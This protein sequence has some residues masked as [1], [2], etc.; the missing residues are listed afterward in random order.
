MDVLGEMGLEE[1]SADSIKEEEMEVMP[2]YFSAVRPVLLRDDGTFRTIVRACRWML[3]WG[4]VVWPIEVMHQG[5]RPA[6]FWASQM[7]QIRFAFMGIPFCAGLVYV[8][9]LADVLHP[10]HGA[11]ALL[12]MG[13]RKVPAKQLV[14]LRRW[15]WM[16]ILPTAGCVVFAA[17]VFNYGVECVGALIRQ[18]P[19]DSP[20]IPYCDANVDVPE[21]PC[22]FSEESFVKEKQAYFTPGIAPPFFALLLGYPAAMAWCTCTPALLSANLTIAFTVTAYQY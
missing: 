5:V 2:D 18:T 12:G 8:R 6:G 17:V 22:C 20:D 14:S 3:V 10:T 1:D 16:L 21:A 9:F 13:V 11:L 7:A 4:L 15:R 19:C